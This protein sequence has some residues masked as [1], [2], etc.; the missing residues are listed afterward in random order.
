MKIILCIM[1]KIE[2]ELHDA[3]AYIE[4]AMAWK[5][6]DGEAADLFYELSTEEMQH[7]E[8]LHQRAV[9]EIETYRQENGEPPAGMQELYDHMHRK[10]MKEAMSIRVKQGM[11]RE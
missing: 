1:E 3:D 4:L 8:K 9:D 6:T 7:M 5:T 10:Y 2:E 11:F